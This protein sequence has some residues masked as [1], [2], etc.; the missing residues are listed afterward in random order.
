MFGS[1][2][3][4]R[5]LMLLEGENRV[6]K[7]LERRIESLEEREGVLLDRL[8]AKNYGEFVLGQN[9]A[10]EGKKESIYYPKD[11]LEENAGE[12]LEVERTK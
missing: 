9:V 12:M 7:V 1:K 2:R 5:I 6:I 8:M 4:D 11:S 3:L 10:D